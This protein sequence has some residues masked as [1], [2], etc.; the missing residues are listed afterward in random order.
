[1]VE[2][3]VD[4]IAGSPGTGG[5]GPPGHEVQHLNNPAAPLK[6]INKAIEIALDHLHAVYDSQTNPNTQAIVWVL[7]GVIGP[8]SVGGNGEVFPI[9]MRDRIHVQ[10]LGA[11][12]CIIRGASSG[13][14]DTQSTFWPTS[15]G[16]ASA[17]YLAKQ[18]LVSYRTSS[19]FF[20]KSFNPNLVH[21]SWACEPET[22]EMLDGF[23]FQGGDVQ[24]DFSEIDDPLPTR[25]RISNCVFD[26]R[27]GYSVTVS[28]DGVPSTFTVNGPSFGL[29]MVKRWFDA[30]IGITGYL[31]Q[32]VHVVNNTFLMA[33]FEHP[34][35]WVNRARQGAVGVIDVTDPKCGPGGDDNELLR[36]LGHPALQNNVFR[37]RTDNATQGTNSM[38]LVG[39][40]LD[41][42]RVQDPNT[43]LF[44]DTNGYPLR[45]VGSSS[46]G[47][48]QLASFGSLPVRAVIT[49]TVDF[50]DLLDLGCST[51]D[52]VWICQPGTLSGCEADALPSSPAVILWDGDPNPAAQEFDPAFIGEYLRTVIPVKTTYRDWR[53]IPG[54]ALRD[55]GLWFTNNLFRSTAGGNTYN[56]IHSES[57]CAFLAF[58][59]WDGEHYGNPRIVD[60]RPDLGFDEIQ[61]GVMCGNFANHSHS[62]NVRGFL[63]PIVENEQL[64]R[65][66]LLPEKV[67]PNQPDEIA[68][69]NKGLRLDDRNQIVPP[70]PPL[71]RR[72]WTNPPGSLSQ[73]TQVVG[74]EAGYNLLYTEATPPFPWSW[75]GTLL[76]TQKRV[77]WPNYQ[78]VP[79]N[80]TLLMF[81]FFRVSLFADD[82]TLAGPNFTAWVNSQ[83]RV[84]GAGQILVGNM[85]AEFR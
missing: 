54:S 65:F 84:L 31:D 9:K 51:S 74:A 43:S 1:M 76:D 18:V 81:F 14:L 39:I 28:L 36:G 79:G 13:S 78:G 62:H 11:G 35:G 83:P 2:I 23:T 30:G 42:V 15:N 64:Q 4:P 27:H 53:L 59:D 55:Q 60:G 44:V 7:P 16:C 49:G 71:P 67:K 32:L 68:L 12:R 34:T 47:S 48:T 37:T 69:L 85:Q 6:T 66:M 41:D 58:A 8:T 52:P 46:S 40:A 17:Q 82:E 72:A 10:G 56:F 21:L 22:A 26:M 63:N 25:G 75:P 33:E 57:P 3:W 61:L 50:G 38:A 29:M 5:G 20:P 73:P 70:Q 45:R 19:R 80:Q 77:Q 24:V